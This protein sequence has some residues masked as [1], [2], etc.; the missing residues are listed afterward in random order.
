MG[1]SEPKESEKDQTET[2]SA[3]PLLSSSNATDQT[4]R[5]TPRKLPK[6]PI[7]LN[8]PMMVYWPEDDNKIIVRNF[9]FKFSFSALLQTWLSNEPNSNMDNYHNNSA[10]YENMN[11]EVP[12]RHKP[13]IPVHHR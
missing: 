4:P 9:I 11:M 1:D 12:Y 7:D 3:I 10:R 13:Q 2:A 5:P 6:F 8:M